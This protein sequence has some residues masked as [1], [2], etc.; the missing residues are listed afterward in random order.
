MSFPPYQN[1]IRLAIRELWTAGNGLRGS[2]PGGSFKV[3]KREK[4]AK[5]TAKF[6]EPVKSRNPDGF[7][8]RS[9]SRRANLE[10]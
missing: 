5:V 1:A 9:S 4:M 3:D 7:V 6:D 2:P 10:E 8:K